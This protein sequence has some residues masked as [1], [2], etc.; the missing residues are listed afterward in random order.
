[1]QLADNWHGA[2]NR[3]FLRHL[4]EMTLAMMLGMCVLGSAFRA[5]HTAVFG[6]D[7]ADV[8]Q[9]HV[10]LAAFAM[11]FNMSLPMVAWMRYRGHSWDRAMEMAAAMFV[12]ALPLLVL[13]WLG[14]VPSGAV[15]P[16]QMV[17]MLPAMVLVMLY[18]LDEYSSP[19]AASH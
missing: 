3:Y 10:E 18:R 16:G 8:W 11:A 15:L 19:H 17:L 4:V 1:M 14:V 9:Q 6:G 12:P 7:F 5:I 13:F 2:A